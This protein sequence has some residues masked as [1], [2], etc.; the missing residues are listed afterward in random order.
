MR[1]ARKTFKTI[2]RKLDGSQIV[3]LLVFALLIALTAFVTV[4]EPGGYARAREL[5]VTNLLAMAMG[6]GLGAFVIR[7]GKKE[8]APETE[9]NKESAFVSDNAKAVL[10]DLIEQGEMGDGF[11]PEKA[12]SAIR[13]L[14]KLHKDGEL[15]IPK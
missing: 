12:E 2:T 5:G 1:Q 7:R 13:L 14:H 9:A 6:M 10:A 8:E 4:N 15:E 3:F 11:A